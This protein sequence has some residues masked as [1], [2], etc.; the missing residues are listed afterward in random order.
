MDAL[1]KSHPIK[2]SLST[3]MRRYPAQNAKTED[4]WNVLSQVSGVLFNIMM[5][6]WT[7][8]AGYPVIHVELKDSILEFKQAS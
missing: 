1:E 4:L 2:K 8:K 5:N 3:Y 6:T 7:R